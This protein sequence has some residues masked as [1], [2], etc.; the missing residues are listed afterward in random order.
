IYGEILG[1]ALEKGYFH[2]RAYSVWFPKGNEGMVCVVEPTRI[3]TRQ[4][5]EH[6][7]TRRWKSDEQV[8][9]TDDR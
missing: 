6:A 1:A 8:M 3:L 7:R 2:A 9:E 5:F 4:E